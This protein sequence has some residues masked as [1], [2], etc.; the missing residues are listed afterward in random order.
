VEEDRGQNR[1][2]GGGESGRAKLGKILKMGGALGLA[3]A[4][5]FS[6]NEMANASPDPDR[7]VITGR[8]MGTANNPFPQSHFESISTEQVFSNSTPST[9][10]VWKDNSGNIYA[11]AQDS[12]LS[13]FEGTDFSTVV[14]NAINALSGTGGRVF[15]KR[16]AYTISDVPSGGTAISLNVDNLEVFGEGKA[17]YMKLADGIS[18]TALSWVFETFATNVTLRDFALDGNKANVTGDIDGVTLSDP[19]CEAE[20]LYI[21]SLTRYGLRPVNTDNITVTNCL[22]EYSEYSNMMPT[23]TS[24]SVIANNISRNAVRN[25]ISCDGLKYCT[26]EGNVCHDNTL[27]GIRLGSNPERCSVVGNTCYNNGG[28]GIRFDTNVHRSTITGNVCHGNSYGISVEGSSHYNVISSNVCL[29]NSRG[30][31]LHTA[32]HN[33][34]TG[35]YCLENHGDTDPSGHNILLAQDNHY[36]VIRGNVCRIGGVSIR[37]EY[38]INV[39]SW[40]P[41]NEDNRVIGNDVYNGGVT[42]NISDAGT[43]TTVERN[44]GYVTENAGTDTQSGDGTTTVFTIAHGLNET[45]IV[46]NVWAESADANGDF[47]VSGKDGTNIEITY[48]SAPP[49]GTNNL[50]WGFEART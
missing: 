44:I 6:V 37:P 12:D 19:D 29:R 4:L 40:T 18:V 42:A 1:A 48:A 24:N 47:Y 46:A 14:Q 7:E 15:I 27:S 41:A 31:R 38:G 34:V 3:A 2:G 8:G 33:L 21:T 28:P 16:G 20:R 39:T 13:S 17:T 35:N 36:N 5:G 43:R 23:N 45:P 49:S 22:L 50:T 26:I 25:G 9:Y 10:V 32:Y 11:D 30:I